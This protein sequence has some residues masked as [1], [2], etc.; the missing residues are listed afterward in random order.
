ME[1]LDLKTFEPSRATVA[2]GRQPSLSSSI[3]SHFIAGEEGFSRAELEGDPTG[4]G[5]GSK[6]R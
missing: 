6:G 2:S 5:L 1:E 4:D 3:S